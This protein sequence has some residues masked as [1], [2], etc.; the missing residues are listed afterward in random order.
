MVLQAVEISDAKQFPAAEK[1]P[2]PENIGRF[3]T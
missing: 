3:S 1:L 2:E